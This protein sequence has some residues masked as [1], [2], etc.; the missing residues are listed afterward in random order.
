M[1]E[2][3]EV[4]SLVGAAQAERVRCRQNLS[5]RYLVGGEAEVLEDHRRRRGIEM[6]E[7]WIENQMKGRNRAMGVGQPQEQ[8]ASEQG[9]KIEAMTIQVRACR[10]YK[11]M[12][13]SMNPKKV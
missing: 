1:A 5:F 13:K 10:R 2:G 12:S 8:L 7:L 3:E 6:V 9:E 4:L 11:A